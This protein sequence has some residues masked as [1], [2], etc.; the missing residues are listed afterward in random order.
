MVVERKF[1]IK[2]K[3][4]KEQLVNR[5]QQETKMKEKVPYKKSQARG[6]RGEGGVVKGCTGRDSE[7]VSSFLK[8]WQCHI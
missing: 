6:E 4:F 3:L 1:R 8:Y 2:C 7:K 5:I